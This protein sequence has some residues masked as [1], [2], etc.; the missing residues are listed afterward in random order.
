MGINV[1]LLHYWILRV[2]G[3][4]MNLKEKYLRFCVQK[5]IKKKVKVQAKYLAIL[6]NGITG[7]CVPETEQ[8]EETLRRAI[9]YCEAIIQGFNEQLDQAKSFL[10][11]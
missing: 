10:R 9:V 2:D 1:R 8:A 5:L 11:R 4:E 6:L 7:V 3:A